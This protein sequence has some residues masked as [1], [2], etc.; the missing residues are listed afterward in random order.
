MENLGVPAPFELKQ[1]TSQYERI[2][3]QFSDATAHLTLEHSPLN[4]IDLPM[5]DEL[6]SAF[7]EVNALPSISIV[8]LSGH[9]TSFSAGVD[10]AAHAPDK[11]AEMLEKFHAIIRAIVSTRKVVLAVVG[12]NCLGGAAELAMVSDILITTE[13][14]NWGFPEIKLGCFPPVA[15]AALSGLIGQKRAADLI[16][17]GRSITGLEAAAIGLATVAVPDDQLSYAVEQKLSLLSELSPSALGLAK[18]AIYAGA[19]LGFD[20]MLQR[21]EKIYLDE[22]MRT[23]DAQEGIRAFLE[24]CPPNWNGR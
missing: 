12:G 21:S 19:T 6:V 16:L 8:T 22:L 20:E 2:N 14:A 18:K 3:L 5:M 9:G 17:T 23:H 13:S 10:V 15:S 1:P 11:I 4:V 7:S 24:K